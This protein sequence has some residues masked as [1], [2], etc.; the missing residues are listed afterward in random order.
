MEKMSKIIQVG[1]RVSPQEHKLLE[2]LA[3]ED[4]R[5]MSDVM[6]RLLRQEAI[7]RGYEWPKPQE[8]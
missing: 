6:R 8:V 5:T 4:E 3:E 1:V 2:M 7:R